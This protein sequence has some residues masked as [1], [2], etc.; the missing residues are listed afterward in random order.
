MEHEFSVTVDASP[1]QVF[2]IVADLGHYPD[3]LDIVSDVTPALDPDGSPDRDDHPP[4]WL[5]T[6]RARLGPLARSKRLRMARTMLEPH[7]QVHFERHEVDGREHATWSL[8]ALVDEIDGATRVTMTLTYGGALWTSLLDPVLDAQV[9]KATTRL[10][11][12]ARS[13][14]ESS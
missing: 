13:G 2:P 14:A 6:L 10:E 5:V 3:L 8:G 11:T 1:A 7:R 12:L 9:R 4:A